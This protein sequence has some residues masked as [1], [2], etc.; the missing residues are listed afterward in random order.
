MLDR[1]RQFLHGLQLSDD[2]KKQVD[3]AID[4]AA[5]DLKA[6]RE[7]FES[8]GA[9]ARE[10]MQQVGQRMR[11]MRDEISGV[12]TEEQ[13]Q[14]FEQRLAQMR[15]RMGN[16]LER[17]TQVLEEVKI[18][19]EQRAKIH[20]VMD[21]TRKR[22]QELRSQAQGGGQQARGKFREVMED[23]R[24]KINEILTEEQRAKFRELMRQREGGPGG[25]P[26]GGGG[27]QR[28]QQQQQQQNEQPPPP[29]APQ[30]VQRG[31]P[32]P[33]F[34]LV[35]LD[36][37]PVQLS[38]FKGR[39]LVVEFG[40]YTCPTFRDR[41]KAMEEL[42][43]DYNTRAQ[44]L[45]IYTK[46]AHPT[47]QW[48]VERNKTEEIEIDQPRTLEGRRTIAKRAVEK[49]DISIPAAIDTMEDTAATAYTGFPNAAFVIS[50]DGKI[51]ARQQWADPA[52][53]ARHIDAALAVKESNTN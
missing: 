40:S 2:Q 31:D 3:T 35:K 42:K 25:G 10:R 43:K 20:T 41:A 34:A 1:A 15:D 16:A 24:T 39:V 49:L 17:L 18:T 26:G 44:F 21:E 7:D 52:A 48:E 47:G 22:L 37:R 13:K 9:E 28:Q 27:E 50:R 12:L 5:A 23:A 4:K 14:Q 19:D 29:N 33:E 51:A 46:E 11:E 6:M 32:A 8:T 53:L 36:G 30:G 45:I 38:S